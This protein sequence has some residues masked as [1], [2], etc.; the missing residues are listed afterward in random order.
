MTEMP[1]DATVYIVDDHDGIRES[2]SKLVATVGLR[3]ATFASGQAFLD[4]VDR[5]CV[6][7]MVTDVRMPMMSGLELLERLRQTGHDLPVVVVTG[8]ADV[9]MAVSAMKLGA[10]EFLEKPARPQVL[11]DH[12]QRAISAHV[13]ISRR[14]NE[15][16]DIERRQSRLTPRES[17]VVDLVVDGMT[18]REIANRL[19]VSPKTVHVHRSEAMSKLEAGSVADLVR[20]IVT[21]REARRHRDSKAHGDFS[22]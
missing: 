16:R 8:Y 14:R 10:V 1:P 2:M 17:E 19:G 3:S 9:P 18:S 7:C 12:I 5:D 11:L 6:G 22:L 20:L 4:E 13:A 15:I 21:A